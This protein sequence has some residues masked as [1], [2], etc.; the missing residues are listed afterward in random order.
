MA[1]RSLDDLSPRVRA[2][3]LA[4]VREC[5]RRGLDV[6]IYCTL[7]S[8]AEQAD[9]YASGRTRPGPILTAARPGESRHNPDADGLA[10]AFDA[11]P[12]IGGKPQWNN[13]AALMLM[14]QAG[15][16]VGLKWAGRWRGRLRERVHF[17]LEG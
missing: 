12:M 16:S 17:Q 1:S 14:G 6:L 11:I 10:W 15:E 9:V 4:F 2:A 7:R 5:Q 8:M 13:D 3:A